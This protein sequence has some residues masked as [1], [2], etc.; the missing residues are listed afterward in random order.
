MLRALPALSKTME[1]TSVSWRPLPR[2]WPCPCPPPWPPPPWPP[3]WPLCS[4]SGPPPWPLPWASP[5]P[6]PCPS[7]RPA[8]WPACGTSSREATRFTSAVVV[9]SVRSLALS[10]ASI[11]RSSPK[12]TAAGS[13]PRQHSRMG[14]KALMSRMVCF[15]SSMSSLLQTS[16]LL[17]NSLSA[18]PTCCADSLTESSLRSRFSCVKKC[19][20]STTVIT[21]S[22]LQYFLTT[23]S[24]LNV[25][26]IGPGSAIPVVSMRMPSSRASLTPS[27]Y[28]CSTLST[29]SL[30][31]CTRSSRTVQQ[32][33]PLSST[34]I[35]STVSRFPTAWSRSWLSMATAPNSF[36]IIAYFLPCWAVRM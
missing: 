4:S 2:P 29:M 3:P 28:L 5:W 16:I 12:G 14:T 23:S 36:S 11:A 27:A 20:Q 32:R 30:M 19:L 33:H 24:L 7:S 34:E 15:V 1:A 6:S 18:N 25:L 35:D 31:A 22:I 17:S 13:V 8:S 10:K 9:C 21:P 26:M